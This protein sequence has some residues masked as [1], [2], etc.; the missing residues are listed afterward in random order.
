[1]FNIHARPWLLYWVVL[2]YTYL[3]LISP[4]IT[5]KIAFSRVIRLCSSRAFGT[6]INYCLLWIEYPKSA[7]NT[8]NLDRSAHFFLSTK[9]NP[10][11]S[12]KFDNVFD[13]IFFQCAERK[14][15]CQYF[16][17]CL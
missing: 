1:V 17:C 16:C 3:G 7:E 4:A 9:F 8:S 12:E 10:N 5:I 15:I 11:L 14:K 13:G 2:I 6:P